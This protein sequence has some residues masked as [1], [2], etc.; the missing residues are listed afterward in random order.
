MELQEKNDA[1]SKI[2][3]RG[4]VTSPDI[5]VH[6]TDDS[7]EEANELRKKIKELAMEI[8]ERIEGRNKLQ[9]AHEYGIEDSSI[10]DRSIVEKAH[11]PIEPLLEQKKELESKLAQRTVWGRIKNNFSRF[12]EK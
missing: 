4:Q 5:L 12:F 1:E 3:H 6:E 8:K 2:E 10:A 11:A 7:A 9:I